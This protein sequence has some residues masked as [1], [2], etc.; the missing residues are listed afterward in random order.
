MYGIPQAGI[1]TNKLLQW[2]LDLDGYHPT[3]NTHGLWKHKT[4]PVW[5]SLVVDDFGIKYIGR[6]NAEHLLASIKENYDISSNWTGSAYC[7]LKLDW[8]YIKGTV[9]LSIHGYIKAALHKYQHPAPTRPEHA[10]H[11]WNTPVYGAKTQYVEDT[12]DIPALSP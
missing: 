9:D 4:C 2:R 6:D 5:F 7:G 8:D 3:E 1:I 10:P 12:Q 11:Q